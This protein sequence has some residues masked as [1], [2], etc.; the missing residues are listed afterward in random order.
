MQPANANAIFSTAGV[1]LCCLIFL[2]PL[3]LLRSA[4]VSPP[5]HR[6]PV[7][8]PFRTRVR[9]NALFPL[10]TCS[11]ILKRSSL[12]PAFLSCLF[13]YLPSIVFSFSFLRWFFVFLLR[14]DF[15]SQPF[16]LLFETLFVLLPTIHFVS[17]SLEFLSNIIIISCSGIRFYF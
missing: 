3:M 14:A 15:S 17:F 6:P 11:W 5:N 8:F 12:F 10:R 9:L 1:T 13:F 2:S 16:H 4:I 7:P